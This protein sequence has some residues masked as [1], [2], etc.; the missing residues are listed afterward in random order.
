MTTIQNPALLTQLKP[1][2]GNP[3]PAAGSG[4]PTDAQMAQMLGN[5]MY[6]FSTLQ[7]TLAEAGE[8]NNQGENTV[9]TA[10]N[11][12]CQAE[13]A[14]QTG[15]L[16]Q[17]IKEQSSSSFWSKFAEAF[18][19][20]GAAIGS[21]IACALGQP[22][23][24]A[25]IIAFTI[26][27]MS[28][29][30]NWVTTQLGNAIGDALVAAGVPQSEADTIGKAVADAVVII[31]TIVVTALSAGATAP[32]LADEVGDEA[33]EAGAQAG[34]AAENA[35]P[36]AE[37]SQSLLSKVWNFIKDTNP[38]AKLSKAANLT[39]LAGAQ[40]FLFSGA[41]S[42]LMAACLVKMKNSQTQEILEQTIGMALNILAA[43]ASAGAGMGASE[44]EASSFGQAI[45]KILGTGGSDLS[46]LASTSNIFK[47]MT[48]AQMG[49]GVLQ[50]SGNIGS[51]VVSSEEA[52]LTKKQ[53]QTDAMVTFYQALENF[54]TRETGSYNKALAAQMQALTT[55]M[56]S[57]GNSWSATQ[58]AVA[59]A[60]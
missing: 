48:G 58:Q 14:E 11:A 16:N 30:M 8:G 5:L 25:V 10:M 28:G 29:G 54:N 41:G 45:Q 57:L 1:M 53:G 44:A 56:S 51:G 9:G 17:W 42:D 22:E 7:S 3:T 32:E 6:L 21:G 55:A 4:T 38:F 12:S 27:S 50:A 20:I 43:A 26:L 13:I 15:E 36:A 34:A 33:V 37:D 2:V 60:L 52:A 31:V 35:A 47:V 23:V 39:I 24:A 59:R 18:E 49:T 40:S 46:S 19:V